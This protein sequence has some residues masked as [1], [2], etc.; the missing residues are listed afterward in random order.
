MDEL[1]L[2][3]TDSGT[4]LFFVLAMFMYSFLYTL[5]YESETV[6][7][8]PVAIV[9]LDNSASSRQ[10]SRMADAT[11]QIHI[12]AKT[13]SL[14][15]AE[16]LFY[17]G[18]INGVIV[19][20][21]HFEKDIFNGTK[22]NVTVYC[23]ASYF[24]LY[25]Q[26]YGGAVYTTGTFNAGVEIKRFLTE[27]KTFNQA[28]TMQEPL[29]TNVYNLYNPSG[30]YGSFVMPGIIIVV[31]QQLLLLGI[32]MLGGTIREKKQFLKMNNS[33]TRKWGSIRLVFAKASTYVVTFLF[34]SLFS[35]V[36]LHKWFSFPDNGHF[37]PVLLLLIPYLYSVSFLGLAISMLFTERI[38]SILFLVFMSPMVVFLSGISWPVSSIPK[39]LY[40]VAH[41]FPSMYMVPAYLKI[42]IYGADIQSVKYELMF[43]I[44]QTI[45]YFALAC[46]AYKLAVKKFG[47]RI[48]SQMPQ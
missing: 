4:L 33:V 13:G 21:Q 17:D 12:I 2:I 44:I 40:Y 45:V 36:M 37:V 48:G 42:R 16:Q 10:Y 18:D 27:G 15:E 23:D 32:G 41:I 31:M 47:R 11:E 3:I 6:K 22:T 14:K 30:G 43:L 19:I 35:M 29:K 1:K 25:K 20:P 9:D 38:Q 46:V 28:V 34:T 39:V 26:V 24:L 7:D 5:A 8:L